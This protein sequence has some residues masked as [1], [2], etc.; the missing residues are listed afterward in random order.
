MKL[1]PK[2]KRAALRNKISKLIEEETNLSKQ[3]VEELEAL[4]PTD[5]LAFRSQIQDLASLNNELVLGRNKIKQ[6]KRK[7]RTIK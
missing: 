5:P 3:V 7:I 4:A 1:T 2:Q 6:L